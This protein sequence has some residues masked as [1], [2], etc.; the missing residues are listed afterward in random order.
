M[1]KYIIAF[2]LL[3]LQT[4]VFAAELVIPD[5]R[6]IDWTSAGVTGGIPTVTDYCITDECNTLYSG[7]ENVT[8]ANINAAIASASGGAS[9]ILVRIPAGSFTVAAGILLQTSNVVLAGAGMTSTTL[10]F[11][12]T[13]TLITMGKDSTYSPT[14]APVTVTANIS[15]GATSFSTDTTT[16]L[17]ANDIVLLK[18]DNPAWAWNAWDDEVETGTK[19]MSQIVKVASVDGTTVNFTPAAVGDFTNPTYTV[20]VSTVYDS[21]KIHHTGLQDMKIVAPESY[22]NYNITIKVPTDSWIKNVHLDGIGSSGFYVENGYNFTIQRCKVD[23]E[24]SEEDGYAVQIVSN[25]SQMLI[26]DNIFTDVGVAACLNALSGSVIAYNYCYKLGSTTWNQTAAMLTHG[27]NPWYNLYEGNVLNG[28]LDA[29]GYHSGSSNVTYFRNSITGVSGKTHDNAYC[30]RLPVRMN[31]YSRYQNVIGNIIGDSSW[32]ADSY[33]ESGTELY[34]DTN[35]IYALGYPNEG[36]NGYNVGDGE[37]GDFPVGGGKAYLQIGTATA[38]VAT[39]ATYYAFDLSARYWLAATEITLSG[40][41]IPTGTKGAFAFDVGTNGTID[42]IPATN[43]A[44]GLSAGELVLR[45]IGTGYTFATRQ[46]GCTGIPYPESNHWRMG[47]IIVQNDSGS[48]FVPGTT[49]L[50]ASGITTT[51]YSYY[52][53]VGGLDADVR[54][55]IL[56]HKNYDYY[57][58]SVTICN[59]ANNTEGCQ[60][61][62][63][64][65]AEDTI[66][67]SLYLTAQP[68]WW[69]T[70]TTWPAVDPSGPTVSKIPAQRRYEGLTCNGG[71][72][73]SIGSG[74]A[75]S[76][77]SGATLTLQ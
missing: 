17:G 51:Y 28:I 20:F 5:A 29:D 39:S 65:A 38:K 25:A 14:F 60:S 21:Y 32:D 24:S 1:K 54:T 48:D 8:T 63:N 30:W 62:T 19:E 27:S 68:S 43:N 9:P 41:S 2:I 66:P 67:N 36:N 64:V 46:S 49:A 42:V 34:C 74:A 6:K 61:A 26:E 33:E 70:E 59:D 53:F 71:V 77:G 4:A 50:N 72:T 3:F 18:G 15:K 69:C 45:T 23:G 40:D 56:R 58:D 35:A 52:N 37:H 16:Y 7:G 76:I 13:T 57:T 75:M 22:T 55:T 11:T 47:Q 73:M 12:G 10:T 44:T 31:R